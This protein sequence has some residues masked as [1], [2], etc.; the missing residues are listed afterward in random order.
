MFGVGDFWLETRVIILDKK[1]LQDY[2]GRRKTIDTERT[3]NQDVS[4]TSLPRAVQRT[5][6]KKLKLRRVVA[7]PPPT[8]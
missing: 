8:R 6:R 3:D 2:T 7:F 5:P 4:H 1:I